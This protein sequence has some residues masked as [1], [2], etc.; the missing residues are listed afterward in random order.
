VVY[1]LKGLYKRIPEKVVKDLSDGAVQHITAYRDVVKKWK[2]T[3]TV[4]SDTRGWVKKNECGPVTVMSR[5]LS[6]ITSASVYDVH[7]SNG[8]AIL[9]ELEIFVKSIVK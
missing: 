8:D 6:K 4:H 5:R 9:K 7:H 1:A 2:D 3:S